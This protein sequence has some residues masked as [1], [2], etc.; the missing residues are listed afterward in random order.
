MVNYTSMAQ[1]NGEQENGTIGGVSLSSFLQ[2]LEQERKTCTLKVN[3]EGREGTFFFEGGE[4]IDAQYGDEVGEAAVYMILSW[5]NPTF[6]VTNA[7][8]RMHRIR[9][10]L[11]HILLD[12][13]KKKD[14]E[15]G[16]DEPEASVENVASHVN[17]AQ[18]TDPVGRRLIETITGI[19]GVKHYYLLNR[20]GQVITQSSRTMKLGDFITYCIVSGI[21]MRKLLNAKGPNRIQLVLENGETLLIIPGAGMIIGLLLDEFTSVNEVAEKLRPALTS[22]S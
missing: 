7:E 4:L 8:D 13:A 2:M 14:E 18:L 15:G 19:A 1:S 22:G 5:D 17:T 21:Q 10:P 6:N 3:A 9:L 20:Q 16:G 11:A 12:F